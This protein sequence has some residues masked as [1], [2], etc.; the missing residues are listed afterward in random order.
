MT[1][2]QKYVLSTISQTR[3]LATSIEASLP[4]RITA[5]VAGRPKQKGRNENETKKEKKQ[6][7][8]GLSPSRRPSQA[9]NKQ[10]D[11]LSAYQSVNSFVLVTK[12][13]QQ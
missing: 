9:Q 11:I 2:R 3:I 1:D 13:Q 6:K 8:D 10:H 12:Q 4:A 7:S 5:D